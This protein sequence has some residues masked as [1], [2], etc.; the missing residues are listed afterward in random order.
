MELLAQKP[1]ELAQHLQLV[2]EVVL[3]RCLATGES[4]M[5]RMLMA[6]ALLAFSG[7]ALAGEGVSI[8]HAWIRLLPADLPAG[9]YFV[10]DNHTDHTVTL[11]GVSSKAFAGAMLHQSAEGT[12]RHIE[13]IHVP[14]GGQLSFAPAGY[15]IMFMPPHAA[16]QP[17]DRVPVTFKFADG[18]TRS[19]D[20]LVKGPAARGW[21]DSQ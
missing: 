17:G 1:S 8:Q 3:R 20:F 15:H 12:M 5:F 4:L 6:G 16:L 19:A 9:G 2:G 10:L 18:S 14:A 21:S 13:S 11:T 7:L